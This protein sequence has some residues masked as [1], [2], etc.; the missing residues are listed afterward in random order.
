MFKKTCL[1]LVTVEI[2]GMKP[3]GSGLISLAMTLFNLRTRTLANIVT[4]AG[5]RNIWK[6]RVAIFPRPLSKWGGGCVNFAA[7]FGH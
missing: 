4:S 2:L 7:L 6:G 5:S 3:V 1:I